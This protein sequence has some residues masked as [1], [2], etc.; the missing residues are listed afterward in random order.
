[1][2]PEGTPIKE[3]TLPIWVPAVLATGPMVALGFA[4]FAY[5]LLLP[6]MTHSLSWSLTTAGAMNTV[7]A[8]GYLLGALLAPWMTRRWRLE[9]IFVLSLVVT[10]FTVLATGLTLVTVLL[11]IFRFISGVSGGVVFVVGGALVAQASANDSPRRA[12]ILLGLYFGGA[13]LGIA[14]SAWIVPVVLVSFPRLGW[15][16]AW[17]IL[18]ILGLLTLLGVIPAARKTVHNTITRSRHDEFRDPSKPGQLCRLSP[19]FVAYG[20]YGSGYI[21]YMTFIIA[22]LQ[23]QG[24]RVGEIVWFWTVLGGVSMLAPGIIGTVLGRTS[25]GR[26]TGGAILLVLAG[27]VLPLWS[28][29]PLAILGSAVLFGSAFLVV[30]TAVT[31]VAR[32]NLPADQWTKALALLTVAFGIGQSLGPFITGW[33]SQNLG[34]VQSGL[35]LSAVILGAG[36]VAAFIQRDYPG[37]LESLA[38]PRC[39]AGE[40][41]T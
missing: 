21:V 12:A 27:V 4:R 41:S 2:I 25:G 23:H 31:T 16:M 34:G 20:L 38:K 1:M 6:A 33:V 9:P 35:L 10:S 30:V 7:N 22:F 18:G 8:L 28:T 24:V 40:E 26:G 37:T 15:Q 13:G 36:A 11:A 17:I 5:A 3:D 19:T 14:L 32:R 29:T 39:E